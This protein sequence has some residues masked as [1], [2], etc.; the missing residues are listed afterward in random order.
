MKK[1]VGFVGWRGT[2]GTVLMQRMLEE[3]DFENIDA[4][5]FSTSQIGKKNSLV[6]KISLDDIKNA[7]DIDDLKKMDIIVTCQGTEY[8]NK[9]YYELRKRNW[10]GYWIDAAASLRME[11][12]SV[13]VLDPINNFFIEESIRR[14]IKTYV[15][16]N[17][18]V[19]LMLLA[20][21][22]LFSNNLIEW[23][24]IHTYQAASGS[25]AESMLELIQQTGV[26]LNNISDVLKS[27]SVLE[28]EKKINLTIRSSHFPTKNFKAPLAYSLIPWIDKEMNSGQ[29][30]EE[31]KVQAE[32]NKILSRSNNPIL[33]DATCVRIGSLRCHSQSF[34]IK[35]KEDLSILEIENILSSHNPWVKVVP[36][37]IKDT[38]L[39]LNP[40]AVTGTLDIPIG[41]IRKLTIGSRYLSAFTVG[42]QLLWGAS[43][44][45][46]RMLKFLIK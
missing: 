20:L 27:S 46:R 41:R 28:I 22:G 18:T 36:N 9:V 5:F 39:Y 23:S 8:T 44:P 15:G 13:I 3:K 38:L 29:S 6:Q 21:G 31:W 2:V 40:I 34:T 17:C 12:D 42:D 33:L 1:S 35:L 11:K 25:G 10:K 26:I 16:S 24:T 30:K 32:T 4:I 43:E 7:Y 14:G 19:S 45:I 37:T